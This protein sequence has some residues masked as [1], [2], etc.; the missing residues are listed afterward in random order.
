[1]CRSASDA[2]GGSASAGADLDIARLASR[3]QL[4]LVPVGF[5]QISIACRIAW[6]QRSH[7]AKRAFF[8]CKLRRWVWHKTAFKTAAYALVQADRLVLINPPKATMNAPDTSNQTPRLAKL[9]DRPVL[10]RMQ[11]ALRTKLTRVWPTRYQ[12]LCPPA[13]AALVDTQALEMPELLP[14]TS[15]KCL[16]MFLPQEYAAHLAALA[17]MTPSVRI[18]PDIG[19][20]RQTAYL[21]WSA[22]AVYPELPMT[23]WVRV[24]ELLGTLEESA[25]MSGNSVLPLVLVAGEFFALGCI[26]ADD[27]LRRQC[28][29][30]M[31]A[32]EAA[33]V[34]YG[35]LE[36]AKAQDKALKYS[37]QPWLL[38]RYELKN[39]GRRLAVNLA[40]VLRMSPASTE[41][42]GAATADIA[43]VV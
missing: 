34:G 23:V 29:K 26:K 20:T 7:Q 31:T 35:E 43:G 39:D 32:C 37:E 12:S 6:W 15:G 22:P 19:L 9:A 8:Y 11:R 33:P 30:A 4:S 27:T 40:P 18:H 13:Y 25:A 38:M 21:S 3:C 28:A 5:D 16:A 24:S 42:K 17:S 1:V 14:T 36:L 41:Q 2:Y 10:Q